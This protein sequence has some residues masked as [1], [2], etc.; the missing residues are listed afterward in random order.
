MFI[1]LNKIDY[2]GVIISKDSVEVNPTKIREMSEWP[3]SKDKQKVQQC[4]EFYN[5]Y[6]CFIKRFAYITK[7]LTK[8]TGKK[9]WR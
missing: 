3:E 9:K 5:F 7:P 4:L 1:L 8:I 2:L 6:R